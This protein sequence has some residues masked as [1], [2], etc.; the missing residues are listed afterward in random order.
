MRRK[1]QPHIW[2]G[3]GDVS[4]YV[5]LPGD[6][7]RVERI[8]TFWDEAQK[9]AEYRGYVTFTG[10][11]QG[12]SVTATSTGIGCPSACIAIEEL[13]K[14]GA[15][16]FIRVG[17][18]GSLQRHIDLGDLVIAT[19]ATRT[20]GTTRAYAPIEYPAVANF[21]VMTALIKAAERLGVKYHRGPVFTS[22]AFYAENGEFA[23]RWGKLG[24]LCVEME[25][26]GLFT[27]A[28]LRG[29]RAG[30]ILAIDGNLLRG[31]KKGEF[32]PGE[33]RGELHPSVTEA[34]DNEIRIALEAI[35]LLEVGF[36]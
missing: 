36:K 8:A 23:K 6:P 22:D 16:T 4:R 10:K 33:S 19:A 35:R 3:V 15:H 24:I 11:W 7:K 21:E 12:I 9:V 32:E 14:V 5:L 30:A 28:R 27:L 25:C 26:S 1:I 17:T 13:A 31:S 20:D 29:L 34:I 18:A 2:C